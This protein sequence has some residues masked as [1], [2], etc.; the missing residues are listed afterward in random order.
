MRVVFAKQGSAAAHI[1][2]R[3]KK[4]RR[5]LVYALV[6]RMIKRTSRSFPRDVGIESAAGADADVGPR[7]SGFCVEA[8]YRRDADYP[9]RCRG[10]NHDYWSEVSA[11]SAWARRIGFGGLRG[12][13]FQYAAGRRRDNAYQ[14]RD[15]DRR[16]GLWT[17][18]SLRLRSRVISSRAA[19]SVRSWRRECQDTRG[20]SW[21]SATRAHHQDINR[22]VDLGMPLPFQCFSV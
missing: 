17:A 4:Q 2:F 8:S 10:R 16:T 7:A 22:H 3:A 20:G 5:P 11:G 9:L 1:Y 6:S 12:I 21:A 14:K 15:C 18:R 13:E 19:T